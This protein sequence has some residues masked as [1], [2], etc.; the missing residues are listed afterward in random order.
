[1]KSKY[2]LFAAVAVLVLC[3]II[4][5]QTGILNSLGTFNQVIAFGI[6]SLLIVILAIFTKR[7]AL[8][9]VGIVFG[10][11]MA[12]LKSFSSG[13]IRVD[14]EF[15]RFLII[16]E[17]VLPVTVTYLAFTHK[18]MQLGWIG[19]LLTAT[20]LINLSML[21]ISQPT[22]SDTLINIM[23]YAYILFVL[24]S[25]LALVWISMVFRIAET[26]AR[27]LSALFPAISLALLVIMFSP[28]NLTVTVASISCLLITVAG[29]TVIFGGKGGYLAVTGML[30]PLMLQMQLYTSI[31]QTNTWIPWVSWFTNLAAYV[32]IAFH[33]ANQKWNNASQDIQQ[34]GNNQE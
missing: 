19:L 1:M 32:L 21:F 30:F 7:T 17:L 2:I 34:T 9:W 10:I 23:F 5:D 8:I 20:T 6:V 15:Y 22:G 33:I 16:I 3:S 27:Y 11:V 12:L 28:Q 25:S 13:L 24:I 14:D 4:A 31:N 26:W 18:Q 29:M